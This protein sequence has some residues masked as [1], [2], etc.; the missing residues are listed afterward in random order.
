MTQ[1]PPDPGVVDLSEPVRKIDP[2]RFAEEMHRA[3]RRANRP[4]RRAFCG[5]VAGERERKVLLAVGVANAKT[6]ETR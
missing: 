1:L 4:F 6:K 3:H 2:Q 5:I